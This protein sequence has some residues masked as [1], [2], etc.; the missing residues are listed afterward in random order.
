MTKTAPS[1]IDEATAERL[2]DAS[3][4][5]DKSPVDLLLTRL[6]H[7]DRMSWIES[8]D[9]VE[10]AGIGAVPIASITDGKLNKESLLDIQASAIS[11][12]KAAL[13]TEEARGLAWL[14]LLSSASLLADH[15]VTPEGSTRAVE[16]RRNSFAEIAELVSGHLSR[17]FQ[18][19]AA[20]CGSHEGTENE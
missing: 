11:S 6:A 16:R 15:G 13:N 10:F 4:A 2:L 9:D 1:P 7:G 3:L 12:L 18:A 14:Y 19:A 17:L 8:R 20:R 5:S